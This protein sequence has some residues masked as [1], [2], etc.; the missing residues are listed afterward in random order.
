M[1]S[2]AAFSRIAP[3]LAHARKAPSLV[4]RRAA[5]ARGYATQSE[6]SVCPENRR[7]PP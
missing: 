4:S 2:R 1:A 5:L 6:H 7:Y 3:A